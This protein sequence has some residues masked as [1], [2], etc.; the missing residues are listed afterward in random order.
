MAILQTQ[1]RGV[2]TQRDLRTEVQ[3]FLTTFAK[4]LAASDGEAIAALFEIPALVI[5]EDGVI[6][7]T[8]TEQAAEFFI[9][10]ARQNQ[11][12][13]VVS[14]RADVIDLE[15]IGDKIMVATV[16]WPHLNADLHE[17]AA[18]ESDYTLRRDHTGA[19]KIRSVL[20]R[21]I[22]TPLPATPPRTK[23]PTH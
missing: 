20:V 10:A 4:A 7:L 8:A 21:G 17:T 22:E 1:P 2:P 18:E 3:D 11:A 19:L 9:A 23:R 15:K 16:R 14:T 13:G 6:A 5:A 12:R